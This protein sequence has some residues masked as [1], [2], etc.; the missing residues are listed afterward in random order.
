[1]KSHDFDNVDDLAL[2]GVSPQNYAYYARYVITLGL[3]QRLSRL[4][5]LNLFFPSERNLGIIGLSAALFGY[6]ACQVGEKGKRN[7]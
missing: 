6:F 5:K 1:M 7:T 2:D 4:I 3:T